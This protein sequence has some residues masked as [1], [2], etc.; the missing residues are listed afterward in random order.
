VYQG[1][2]AQPHKRLKVRPCKDK[3]THQHTT[4]LVSWLDKVPAL[5]CFHLQQLQPDLCENKGI[6]KAAI[7]I[8][9]LQQACRTSNSSQ[10]NE[11]F[12]S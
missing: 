3:D 11:C 4:L 1:F 12:C 9:D 7:A 2:F 6:S 8:L 10:T 5:W